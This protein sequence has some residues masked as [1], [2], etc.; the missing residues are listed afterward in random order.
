M[1]GSESRDGAEV[2]TRD[3]GRC[4]RAGE[5]A[6]GRKEQIHTTACICIKAHGAC[7][8]MENDSVAIES[9]CALCPASATHLLCERG[10]G[11]QPLNF[12]SPSAKQER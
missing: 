4:G 2:G 5:K 6:E 8:A 11:R 10:H 12:M 9:D 1:R 3:L 7:A